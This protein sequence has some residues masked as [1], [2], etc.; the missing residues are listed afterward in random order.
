M[1]IIQYT[2]QDPEVFC[3]FYETL[4]Y[5]SDDLNNLFYGSTVP[6]DYE[7]EFVDFREYMNAIGKVYTEALKE[8]GV[9]DG[10]VE[11]VGIKSPQYYNFHTDQLIIRADVDLRRLKQFVFQERRTEFGK[12]LAEHYTTRS[13]FF[14]FIENAVPEFQER[15]A[16]LF[17]T[18][19][20]DNPS[21]QAELDVHLDI[22]IDFLIVSKCNLESVMDEVLEQKDEILRENICL[23]KYTPNGIEYYDY[24][25][26]GE[27]VKVG[28]RI[29]GKLDTNS[30]RF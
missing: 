22:M 1:A 26:D 17:T 24:I 7:I 8:T 11:F 21:A 12:Y 25:D 28:D 30:R 16:T 14:S 2:N 10:S 9:F 4:L 15:L 19:D 3:G 20:Y 27:T 18:A 13:G 5:G 23:A 29:T 6:E